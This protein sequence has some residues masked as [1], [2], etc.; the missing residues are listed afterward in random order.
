M[1]V[2]TIYVKIETCI[3]SYYAWCRVGRT[4]RLGQK[5]DSLLFLQPIETDYL[6]DLKRHGVSLT[7]YPLQ[8][9]LDSFPLYGQKHLAKR[10]ISIEM[11]PWLVGLQKALE[12]FIS[13]EVFCWLVSSLRICYICASSLVIIHWSVKIYIRRCFFF[14]TIIIYS[15]K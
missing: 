1:T 6:Q 10:L 8:K 7:E 3:C 14:I 9:V 5:G 15:L 2:D 13:A 11:H 4:A 12:A